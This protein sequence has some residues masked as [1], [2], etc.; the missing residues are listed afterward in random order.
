MNLNLMVFSR[1]LSKISHE[2]TEIHPL[3]GHKSECFQIPFI[4]TSKE[5]VT[6]T[7]SLCQKVY[8]KILLYLGGLD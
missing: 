8:N 1:D 4:N 6:N 5:F 7:N 2:S 3:L